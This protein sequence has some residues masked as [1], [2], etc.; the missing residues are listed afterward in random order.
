M[1]SSPI[2]INSI[3]MGRNGNKS[4]DLTERQSR[5]TGDPAGK[6]WRITIPVPFVS[7]SVCIPGLIYGAEN[8][9]SNSWEVIGKTTR[10]DEMTWHI[11][12]EFGYGWRRRAFPLTQFRQ[13]W[14]YN[15]R[16]VLF[17]LLFSKNLVISNKKSFIMWNFLFGFA[18]RESPK[19]FLRQ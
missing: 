3:R 5:I 7:A 9:S 19:C 14:L 6:Q 12:L 17:S 15:I 13:I 18:W 16:S 4:N 1:N 11:Y 8:W 10:I 2:Y